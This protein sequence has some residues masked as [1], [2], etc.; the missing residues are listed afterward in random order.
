MTKQ[1]SDNI[2]SPHPLQ[3]KPVFRYKPW[4]VSKKIVTDFAVNFTELDGYKFDKVGEL[5]LISTQKGAVG[6]NNESVGFTPV[7]NYGPFTPDEIIRSL[8]TSY[9]GDALTPRL[10]EGKDSLDIYQGKPEGWYI[11]KVKGNVEIVHGFKE[12][13]T[14]GE[15]DQ[16]IQE[17]Y[18]KHKGSESEIDF[19]ER[20]RD[21]L[22]KTTKALQGEVYFN[23]P[24]KFHTAVSLDDDSY[25]II[26]EVQKGYDSLTVSTKFLCVGTY[27]MSLQVHPTKEQV[28]EEIIKDRNSNIAKLFMNDP[29][30]RLCDILKVEGRSMHDDIISDYVNFSDSQGALVTTPIDLPY[31][32]KTVLFENN[33]FRGIKYELNPN[34]SVMHKLSDKS[35]THLI[36]L[37]GEAKIYGDNL[38]KAVDTNLT[39]PISLAASKG[40]VSID[41]KVNGATIVLFEE[42]I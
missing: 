22:L 14:K 2:N 33:F 15:F 1:I 7:T 29:S 31:G 9:L 18:F 6:E 8:G 10:N 27:G 34:S 26:L 39:R 16:L 20:V 40:S 21:R 13:V 17:G 23:N 37:E 36:T 35:Y 42:V 41:S 12:G 4:G 24:G 38:V 25:A 19:Y 11:W 30:L 32:T 28:Q 3:F 5:F